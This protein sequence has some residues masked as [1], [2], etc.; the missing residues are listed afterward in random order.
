[1][2]AVGLGAIGVGY[3]VGRA[4]VRRTFRVQPAVLAMAAYGAVAATAIMVRPTAGALLV[5]AGLLAHAAWDVYHYRANKVVDRSLAEFCGVLDTL[6]R[7]AVIGLGIVG[8]AS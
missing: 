3:T 5:G 4:V 1:M 7:V 2:G 8:A 6:L